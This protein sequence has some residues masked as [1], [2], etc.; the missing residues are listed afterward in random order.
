M[1]RMIIL[2]SLLFL[3]A[4][5]ENADYSIIE[6]DIQTEDGKSVVRLSME[7]PTDENIESVIEELYQGDYFGTGSITARIHEAPSGEEEYGALIAIAKY[8]RSDNGKA[9]VGVDELN[10]VY[11]EK[12]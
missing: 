2:F 4:C 12:Q 6:E 5:G 8:A 11:I 3:A 9:Q 1:K 10:K 7:E